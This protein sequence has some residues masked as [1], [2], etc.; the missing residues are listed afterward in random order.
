MIQKCLNKGCLNLKC[1]IK[2]PL[3]TCPHEA[4]SSLNAAWIPN[5]TLCGSVSSRPD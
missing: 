3:K 5:Q 4:D 2:W 1:Q